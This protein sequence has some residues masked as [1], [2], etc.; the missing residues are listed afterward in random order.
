MQS[1]GGSMWH[2][3]LMSSICSEGRCESI[4]SRACHSAA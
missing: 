4:G 3:A 1:E 2:E